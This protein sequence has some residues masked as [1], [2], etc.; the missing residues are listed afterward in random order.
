VLCRVVL[1][2]AVVVCCGCAVVVRCGL[3]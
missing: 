2:C 1:R 3:W